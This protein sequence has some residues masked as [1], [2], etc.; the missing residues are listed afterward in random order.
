LARITGLLVPHDVES[1][2]AVYRKAAAA[3]PDV[4]LRLAKRLGEGRNVTKNPAEAMEW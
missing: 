2:L 4:A 3:N 1:G